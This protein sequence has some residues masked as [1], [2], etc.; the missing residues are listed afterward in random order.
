MVR[1][2]FD[3]LIERAAGSNVFGSENLSERYNIPKHITK[4]LEG[5]G[6]KLSVSIDAAITIPIESTLSVYRV[7]PADFTQEQVDKIISALYDGNALHTVD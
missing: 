6:G 2:D 1:K 3:I 5:I 7:T 4:E